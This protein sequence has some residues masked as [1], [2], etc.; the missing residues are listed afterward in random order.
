[1]YKKLD[2]FPIIGLTGK[3]RSGK[4]TVAD[5]M[6]TN[7]G[8]SKVGFADELKVKVMEDFNL[9]WEQIYGNDK[10]KIVMKYLKTPREILQHMG[11][12]AYRAMYDDFWVEKLYNKLVS[13]KVKTSGGI[14]ITDVRFPNEVKFIK[15]IGGVV[16]QIIRENKDEINGIKN[17]SSESSLDNQM[18][19]L[20]LE[21]NGTII[22]LYDSIYELFKKIKE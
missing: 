2:I 21:N 14:V 9:S 13:G 17:H 10:E 19:D 7:Y 5:Y 15:D 8:V 18:F 22:E 20:V 4:D 11:T 16:I 1:M 6:V 3:A 12:E